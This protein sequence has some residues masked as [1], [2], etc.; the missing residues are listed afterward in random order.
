MRGI[1]FKSQIEDRG[2][3]AGTPPPPLFSF[4][5]WS[6]ILDL[7]IA[8]QLLEKNKNV[9]DIDYLWFE[10]VLNQNKTMCLKFFTKIW[11]MFNHWY[12]YISNLETVSIHHRKSKMCWYDIPTK[13]ANIFGIIH[14]IWFTYRKI[15]K[16]IFSILKSNHP[17]QD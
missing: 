1:H 11:F 2:R 8:K 5:T 12:H 17:K 10:V 6:M 3:E 9:Y 16:S 13:K 7:E 4:T 15:K 14:E